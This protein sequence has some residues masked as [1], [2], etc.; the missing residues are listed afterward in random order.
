MKIGFEKDVLAEYKE[1]T[2]R[3]E[4]LSKEVTSLN[5]N[6]VTIKT[7]SAKLTADLE[8][9][10]AE[11]AEKLSSLKDEV[12]GLESSATNWTIALDDEVDGAWALR[13]RRHGWFKDFA[14]DNSDLLLVADTAKRHALLQA[15]EKECWQWATE[16]RR[17]S[18]IDSIH[19]VLDETLVTS[20][21]ASEIFE[22]LIDIAFEL[23]LETTSR[24]W[25]KLS[26]VFSPHWR[27]LSSDLQEKIKSFQSTARPKNGQMAKQLKEALK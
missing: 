16:H 20:E 21:N 10:I 25:R 11:A 8:K 7:I 18:S 1:L 3:K 15:D 6:L 13:E 12:A 2:Q 22:P 9:E 14:N 4:E 23:K 19:A 27:E 26:Q 17:Q 5:A 24:T